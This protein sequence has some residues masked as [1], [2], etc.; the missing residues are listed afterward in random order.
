[1]DAIRETK[2][3]IGRRSPRRRSER[4]MIL[5][6][7]VFCLLLLMT[8]GILMILSAGTETSLSANYR[9][10]T[11]AYYAALNGLEEGRGRLWPK[12]PDKLEPYLTGP[13]STLGVGDVIYILN[14]PPS[15][16]VVP[17]DL[18]SS[19]P[20]AD[21]EY[22]TEFLA[23]VDP[24]RMQT[25]DSKSSSP[26]V[27]G[28]MY[29]WVRIN[30]ATE[31]M[32]NVDVNGGGLD[33]TIPLYYD[34]TKLNLS[35]SGSEVFEITSLA[36]LPDKSQRLVQYIVAPVPLNLNLPSAVTV[37]GPVNTFNGPMQN[38]YYVHGNDREHGE[39]CSS[40]L[41]T[42]KS[43]VGIDELPA[44]SD[45][46][47]D[48]N[49]AVVYAGVPW[50]WGDHYTGYG[51]LDPNN[52]NFVKVPRTKPLDT[53][54][55]LDGPQGLVQMVRDVADYTLPGPDTTSLPDYGTSANPVIV[56][57]E[58]NLTLSSV[59]GY[60]LLLVTGQLS[61]DSSFNWNGIILVVG[62]GSMIISD[63][64]GGGQIN[65]AVFI[66]STR[67][68]DNTLRST[69]G[70]VNFDAQHAKSDGIYYNSC[71]IANAQKSSKIY[72]PLS[73]RQIEQP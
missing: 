53:I 12:H 63:F 30:A 3:G 46:A 7:V 71:S 18:S 67:N 8:L 70:P 24:G 20:Y 1:M 61:V 40:P 36:V 21:R 23:P 6:I 43:A 72:K 13:G 45:I 10:S 49:Y 55:N 65:G 60:G 4:G 22:Q 15:A 37:A 51:G 42:G 34:G 39:T 66:A 31:R 16:D 59:N 73:F 11:Q 52:R 33:N 41:V 28:P 57:V 32:L 25:I 56:A 29:E 47:D 58:G 64:G 27:L 2:P 44:Y 68:P 19:N 35:S 26:G 5:L 54:A 69:L 17:T 62:Q 9:S 48:P 14:R 50:G 38:I